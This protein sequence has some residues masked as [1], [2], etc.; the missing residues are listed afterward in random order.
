MKRLP[1]N[2]ILDYIW[3]PDN[4]LR[5]DRILDMPPIEALSEHH[6]LPSKLFPSDHLPIAAEFHF[7]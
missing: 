1:A 2:L 3:F 7:I 6:A 4:L 5:V